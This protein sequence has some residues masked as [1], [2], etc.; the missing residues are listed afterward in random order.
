M[1]PGFVALIAALAFADN[2]K[3][4][5]EFFAPG[6]TVDAHKTPGALGPAARSVRCS[7]SVRCESID[8]FPLGQSF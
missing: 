6:G 3:P 5:V 1:L 8:S 7:Q 2:T 4:V